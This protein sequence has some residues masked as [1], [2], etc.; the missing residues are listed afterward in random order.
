MYY[1]K[2]NASAPEEFNLYPL[3]AEGFTWF[4]NL[5]EKKLQ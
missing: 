3:P 2:H 4:I 5:R 1:Y